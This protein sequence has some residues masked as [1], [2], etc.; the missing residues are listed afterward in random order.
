MA[1]RTCWKAH[2]PDCTKTLA[3]LTSQQ[4]PHALLLLSEQ[5]CMHMIDLQRVWKD[6]PWHSCNIMHSGALKIQVAMVCC[7]SLCPCRQAMAHALIS[8]SRMN[9]CCLNL[10]TVASHQSKINSDKPWGTK[11]FYSCCVSCYFSLQTLFCD[12]QLMYLNT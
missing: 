3:L 9:Q 2:A 5:H 10:V 11:R 7:A 12:M 8:S 1:C 6:V 4:V